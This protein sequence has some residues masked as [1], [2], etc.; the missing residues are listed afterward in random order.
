MLDPTH[1]EIDFLRRLYERG[2]RLTLQ[3]S[4]GLFKIDR[5]FPDYVT[6]QSA[7]KDTVHFALTQKGHMLVWQLL[8]GKR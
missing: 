8:K 1:D 7:G 4:I 6:Q 3:G 5:L 2:G